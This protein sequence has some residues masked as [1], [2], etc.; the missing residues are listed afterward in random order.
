MIKA[1]LFVNVTVEYDGYYKDIKEVIEDLKVLCI[2]KGIDASDR[3]MR[4]T[5]M[6]TF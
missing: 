4:I 2:H 6:E 5:N 1:H 3:E